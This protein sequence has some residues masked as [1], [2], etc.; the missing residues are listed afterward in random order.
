MKI[1]LTKRQRVKLWMAAKVGYLDTLDF[2][3]LF[4]K[5]NNGNLFFDLLRRTGTTEEE[6][7][8]TNTN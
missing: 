8:Q 4:Y 3:E 5:D 2:P 1:E 7:T 6:E